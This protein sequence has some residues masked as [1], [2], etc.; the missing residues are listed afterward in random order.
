[1]LMMTPRQ[2]ADLAL[3]Q[4]V[5]E[6]DGDSLHRLAA[7]GSRPLLG[8]VPGAAQVTPQ[9]PQINLILTPDPDSCCS[10]VMLAVRS[11][12]CVQGYTS[13]I[14]PSSEASMVAQLLGS[15]LS[16]GARSSGS[17][18]SANRSLY[19]AMHGG[20]CWPPALIVTL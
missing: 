9:N 14:L 5:V 6:S 12:T 18:Q 20:G 11:Q 16:F 1:M 19:C 15:S 10:S 17:V 13:R 8:L 7:N 4:K 2:N 3:A